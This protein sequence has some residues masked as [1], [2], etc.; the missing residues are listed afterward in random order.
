LTN[1]DIDVIIFVGIEQALQNAI[2]LFF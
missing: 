2:V 1:F